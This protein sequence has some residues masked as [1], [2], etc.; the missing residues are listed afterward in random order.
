MGK[1]SSFV[2]HLMRRYANG[3]SLPKIQPP[4]DSSVKARGPMKGTMVQSPQW[5]RFDQFVIEERRGPVGVQRP[6]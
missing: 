6:P 4:Y 3:S 1:N 5:T 2:V